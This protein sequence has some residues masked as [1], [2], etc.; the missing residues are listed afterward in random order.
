MA[1]KTK[2]VFDSVPKINDELAVGEDLQFQQKWWRFENAVWVLF[3][4]IILLDLLGVFG[5]GPLANAKAATSD[6][7]LDVQYERV[8]RFGTPSYL[9][10]HF[11]SNAI[12][13]GKVQLWA[14]DSLLKPLGNQRVIPQ[15]SAS[16]VGNGGV[17]Y[18]F[19][20]SKPPALAGFAL[21]PSKPG[22]EELTFRVPGFQPLTLRILVMP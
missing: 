17:L 2:P 12:R 22:I 4:V 13:A 11:G 19:D 3:A 10:I 5:R 6:G 15:P 9:T 20:A 21:E 7:S 1:T 18:T 8:E 16:E 14:S